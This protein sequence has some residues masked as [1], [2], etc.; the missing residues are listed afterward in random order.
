MPL[1]EPMEIL[2]GVILLLVARLVAPTAKWNPLA[3]TQAHRLRRADC[4]GS[5]R[6][7]GIPQAVIGQEQPPPRYS[8]RAARRVLQ[9]IGR[10]TRRDGS[11]VSHYPSST[12]AA[13]A[14]P[15]RPY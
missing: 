1:E 5:E 10:A 3:R 12:H 9:P 11:L 2:G 15:S 7:C 6:R 14:R 13:S 8:R 4:A